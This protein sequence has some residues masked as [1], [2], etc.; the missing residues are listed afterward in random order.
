MT[1]PRHV[2]LFGWEAGREPSA[3]EHLTEKFAVLGEV[4]ARMHKHS[5]AWTRP[6]GFERLTWDFDT[7]LG[8][9][10]HWGRWADGMGVDGRDGGAVRPGGGPDR[11]AARRLRQVA[12]P[13][14]PHPFRHA[15]RQPPD[16]RRDR[17]GHRFRRLRLLLAPLRRGDGGLLLRARE[18]CAGTP[19]LLGRGLSEGAAS[20]GGRGGR[21][22]DL[23]HAAADAP[24]RLDRL[25]FGDRPRAV[26]GRGLHRTD[27]CRSA[28]TISRASARGTGATQSSSNPHPEM[29]A[30]RASKDG[31]S[32][33]SGRGSAFH[34]RCEWLHGPSRLGADAPRTSG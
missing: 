8:A 29:R 3:S 9:T 14:R 22:A 23:R 2:V 5:E 26:D 24:R 7:S 11:P 18:P 10:P 31:A 19:R 34:Q 33:L 17:E 20:L 1:E 30:K 25:A 16:R 12:G 32:G 28:R 21:A 4:T 6:A 27:R 13:L 15:A